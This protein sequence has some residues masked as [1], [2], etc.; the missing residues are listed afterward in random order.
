[1]V[2]AAKLTRLT[3]MHLVAETSTSCSRRSRRPVRKL[4][5]TP[6]YIIRLL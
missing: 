5:D 3:Q 4:F 2:M 1:M 6:S